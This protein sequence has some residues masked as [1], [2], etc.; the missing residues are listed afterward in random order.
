MVRS[1]SCCG[2]CGAATRGDA[3][4]FNQ[5]GISAYG[6]DVCG[7]TGCPACYM[8]TDP[9][10]FATCSGGQCTLLDLLE[11]DV[12]ACTGASDCRI[13]T[14]DCCECGGGMGEEDILAIAVSQESAFASLACDPSAECAECAPVYPSNVAAACES[15]H[16]VAVWSD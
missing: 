3:I 5:E 16:C 9:T 10:L 1:E 15:G 8:P 11:E 14:A 2:T 13:R 6:K 7:T 4:T 12:T